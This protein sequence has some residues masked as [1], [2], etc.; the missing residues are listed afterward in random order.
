[1]SSWTKIGNSK[2]TKDIEEA[3]ESVEGVRQR[4]EGRGKGRGKAE[5]RERE[6]GG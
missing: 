5:K 4:Y 6:I 2:R 3:K 1:M